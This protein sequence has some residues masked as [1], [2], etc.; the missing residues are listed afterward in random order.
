MATPDTLADPYAL[1]DG[2]LPP[3]DKFDAGSFPSFGG[4]TF[5]AQ[6]NPGPTVQPDFLFPE[7]Y[8]ENYRR[9]WGER[10]TFHIGSAYLTGYTTGGAYGL[11][12]GLKASQGERR[13]IRINSVLN[14]MSQRGPGWGN[15]LGSIAL[16]WSVFETIAYSWRG[17]DDLLNPAGAAVVTGALYRSTAGPRVAAVTGLGLGAL[18]AVG[19]F[20]AKHFSQRGMLKNFL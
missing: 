11:Y 10:L 8:E 16:M 18:A 17:T 6:A 9:S 12:E 14:C 3:P 15:S 2:A 19:S 20:A 13:R 7:N 5:P 1:K 4:L